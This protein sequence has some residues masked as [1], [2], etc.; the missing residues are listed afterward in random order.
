MRVC[1][2]RHSCEQNY[3]TL[4]PGKSQPLFL[5]FS[6]FFR[7]PRQP[8]SSWSSPHI[9]ALGR[10]DS[11]FIL[12][13]APKTHLFSGQA[14]T[15]HR[16]LVCARRWGHIFFGGNSGM[17][18]KIYSGSSASGDGCCG[19]PPCP[20]PCCPPCP[21]CP[22][23]CPPAGGPTGP[24]GPTGATGPTGGTG[25]TGATGATGPIGPTGPTGANGATGP[26]G[27]VGP[28]GANGL[29]GPT[30]A[31]GD[32]GPTGATGAPG[33]AGATGATGATAPLIYAQQ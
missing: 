1:Q 26:T 20:Q 28:T 22:P 2:F 33:A 17:N 18:M 7:P 13:Q 8:N 32:T 11:F 24:T 23:P 5:F 31:R 10:A 27:A 9:P 30:G 16:P 21:P 3:H 19:L 14:Y 6:R 4:F 15:E 25:A 29:A 12:T